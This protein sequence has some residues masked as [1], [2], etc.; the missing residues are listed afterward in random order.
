MERLGPFLGPFFKGLYGGVLSEGLAW[1]P[2]KPMF[3]KLEGLER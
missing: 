1:G 2:G 3:A